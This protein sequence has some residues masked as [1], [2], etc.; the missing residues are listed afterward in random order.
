[1]FFEAWKLDF[2]PVRFSG[3]RWLE[4]C[5]R[6]RQIN[7]EGMGTHFSYLAIYLLPL[8]REAFDGNTILVQPLEIIRI[9]IGVS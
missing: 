3:S 6:S 2:R 7:I 1:M 9:Y 8:V 5:V 4:P